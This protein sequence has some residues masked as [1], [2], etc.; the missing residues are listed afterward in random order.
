MM[1]HFGAG[2]PAEMI[3]ALAAECGIL[4][5]LSLLVEDHQCIIAEVCD[6]RARLRLSLTGQWQEFAWRV[7]EIEKGMWMY[8]T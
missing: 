5:D 8:G 2:A 1:I 3:E 4:G 6:P 7:R